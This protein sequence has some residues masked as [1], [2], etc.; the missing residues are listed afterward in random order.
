MEKR[1]DTDEMEP[2]SEMGATLGEISRQYLRVVQQLGTTLQN[3]DSEPMK[4][5]ADLT[6]VF[7]EAASKNLFDFGKMAEIN[8]NAF[9]QFANMSADLW[10][11][12]MNVES[13]LDNGDSA[14]GD[15]RFRSSQWQE[16]LWFS[17][18]HQSYS[19]M[20][21][22]MRGFMSAP[23][24]MDPNDARKL[25][26]YTEQIC[27]ALAPT[28]YFWTNPDAMQ[29]A[30]KTNG[31]SIAQG[32]KNFADDLEFGSGVKMV[33]KSQF[34]LGENLATTPGKVIARNRL[35]ELIQY[36]PVRSTVHATPI[37]IVPPWINKFYILDMKPAN[38]FIGWLVNQGYSVFVISWIN[39]DES[40]RDTGFD[41][42]LE[43]GPLWAAEQIRSATGSEQVNAIGYCIGG[44]LLATMLGY[45][46]QKGISPIR[47]AT[48][49]TTMIDFSEPGDLGVFV[50]EQS[51]SELEKTMMNDGYLDGK[52]MASTFSM[53]RSNDLI[54]HF[55]A[56]NYLMGKDPGAFDL[57]YWN[58][59]STRM[60]ARM[61][62]EYLRSM[63]LENRLC[64][65]GA[66]E[67][68]GKPIDL[69]KVTVPCYFLSTHLD[70]IAP[71][72]STYAGARL[73]SGDVRFT[74]GESG[75]IAG[76][77]N[78]PAKKKYGYWTSDGTLSESADEWLEQAS[79]HKGSWWPDWKKW[80][81]KFNG[82]KVEAAPAGSGALPAIE[83]APGSYVK[84]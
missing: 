61:H 71:W 1:L 80:M 78:P 74:L 20:S 64:T 29:E 3:D 70:H 6:P 60:P 14:G 32:L 72:K 58:S 25:E 27:D 42:Y 47:S 22:Y 68:M 7:A 33:D 37:M 48:F 39:P 63:Y 84:L 41:D 59:D 11:R 8:A 36:E 30:S 53:M 45:C 35:A 18:M 34:R 31:K 69:S 49:L 4:A 83:D 2:H 23:E 38:S 21:R 55:V 26:F 16:N 15:P 82:K 50:D 24:G 9:Q 12:R 52:C 77:V 56:N 19:I 28:N 10:L 66:L 43:S 17:A 5:S 40:Y 51:V 81:R 67:V 75:H 44:T 62:S 54:W 65:P 13:S 73:L 46:A 76:V 79:N 57:L